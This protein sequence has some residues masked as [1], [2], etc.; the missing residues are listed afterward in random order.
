MGGDSG[1]AFQPQIERRRKAPGDASGTSRNDAAPRPSR[2]G[3]PRLARGSRPTA[4]S[5][6]PL[7]ILM[8]RRASSSTLFIGGPLSL[9]AQPDF[10]EDQEQRSPNPG[11]DQKDGHYLAG[12]AAGPYRANRTGDG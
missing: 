2:L 5:R 11:H 9:L 1:P 7:R 3:N 4:E 12:Q 8:L 10:E 6:A